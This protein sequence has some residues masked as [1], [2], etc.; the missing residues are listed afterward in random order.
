MQRRSR[1]AVLLLENP[2][3]VRGLG[4]ALH[5]R[6]VANFAFSVQERGLHRTKALEILRGRSAGYQ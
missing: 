4:T 2:G 3:I 1:W 5:V 6:L